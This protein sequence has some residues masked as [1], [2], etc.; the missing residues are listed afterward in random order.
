[1]LYGWFYRFLGFFCDMTCKYAKIIFMSQT[2]TL[3]LNKNQ[4]FYN[5]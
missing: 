5:E 4:R 2:F 3:F 1:M